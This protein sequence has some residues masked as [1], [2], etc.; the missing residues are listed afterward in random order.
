MKKKKEK[1]TKQV[2]A[3]VERPRYKYPSGC[4]ALMGLVKISRVLR[5]IDLG[6]T[7]MLTRLSS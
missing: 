4:V 6:P 1:Q 3:R 5:E 2:D 7:S